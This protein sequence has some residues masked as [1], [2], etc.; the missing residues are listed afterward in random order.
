[1]KC[2][3]AWGHPCKNEGVEY[4]VGSWLCRECANAEADEES[5]S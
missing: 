3:G 4:W 1:M 5:S 2:Q